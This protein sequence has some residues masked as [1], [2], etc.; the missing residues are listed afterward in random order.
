VAQVSTGGGTRGQATA[1]AEGTTTIEASFQG[2]TGSATLTV[3]AATLVRIQV[4]PFTPTLYVGFV[5]PFNATGIY[6]DNTTRDLTAL[7]TWTSSAPGVAAV[8]NAVATR[9]QVTPLAAGKTTISAV[10]QGVTGTDDVAVSSAALVAISVTPINAT[11]ASQASLQ[12]AATGTFSDNSTMDVT[13]YVTWASSIT[14][15]ADVS[16]AAT[17]RGLAKGFSAGS[18]SISATRGSITG[19]TTL[20][21]Q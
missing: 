16:N 1:L 5:T 20:T 19:S 14:V 18:T 9:G 11:I 8:S 21:V 7:A 2:L 4:T 17:S 12:F 13:S 6:S 15:V 10:Y 3:T